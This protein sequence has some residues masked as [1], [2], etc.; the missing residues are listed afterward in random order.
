MANLNEVKLI[1]RLGRDPEVRYMP[2]GD[3]LAN[4]TVATSETYKDKSGEK[5]EST[6]WHR[7]VAFRQPATF[8]EQYAKKGDLVFVEG[9]LQTRE[10]DKNGEKHYTTEIVVGNFQLLNSLNGKKAST[11]EPAAA[12]GAASAS[13]PNGLDPDDD[14]PY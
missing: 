5:K 13:P 10:Y 14:P 4:I 1:G 12:A 2:S 11:S 6:E 3:A 8:I 9:K 7:C